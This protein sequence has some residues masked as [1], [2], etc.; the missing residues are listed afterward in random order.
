MVLSL[1]PLKSKFG[2]S[3]DVDNDVTYS[4]HHNTITTHYHI[5]VTHPVC[6]SNSPLRSITSPILLIQSDFFSKKNLR[7]EEKRV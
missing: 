2:L 1:D 3:G 7:K 5:Y 6:P 4:P